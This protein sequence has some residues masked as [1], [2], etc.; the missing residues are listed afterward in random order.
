MGVGKSSLYSLFQTSLPPDWMD[1]ALGMP[2]EHNIEAQIRETSTDIVV[3]LLRQGR[4]FPI[5]KVAFC[6][7]NKPAYT[8]RPR[9][10]SL[11]EGV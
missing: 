3:L 5:Q 1:G 2:L 4:L 9:R 8:Q 11:K 7:K 10:A 6:S